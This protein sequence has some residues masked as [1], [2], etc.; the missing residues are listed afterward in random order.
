METTAHTT[1]THPAELARAVCSAHRG[2]SWYPAQLPDVRSALEHIST[3]M[4][5]PPYAPDD[6]TLLEEVHTYR[7]PVHGRF[8]L[9]KA[10]GLKA[11]P[12]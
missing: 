8:T 3:V 10:L 1:S 11:E 4:S 6:L 12:I 2:R 5:P 7:C 9:T